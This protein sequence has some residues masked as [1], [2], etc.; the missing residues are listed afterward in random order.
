LLTQAPF[1]S[2]MVLRLILVQT[3]LK[4]SGPLPDLDSW[5]GIQKLMELGIV[6][7][8]TRYS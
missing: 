4:I 3:S 1:D 8:T 6:I 2:H 5:D 7:T